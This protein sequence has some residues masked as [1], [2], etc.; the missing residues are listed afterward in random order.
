MLDA[1]TA[2]LTLPGLGWVMVAVVLAG[3]VYGFAGFGAALVYMPIA[4]IFL[5]PVIAVAAFALS[6]LI[7]LVTVVPRAWAN[8]DRRATVELVVAS[9]VGLPFGLWA[10]TTFD[11]TILR[12]AVLVVVAITL[13]VLLMGWRRK[14]KEGL[15][16]RAAIGAATGAVGGAT[17]LNGPVLVLFQL[18]SRD[19]AERSRANTICF[20]TFNS[21]LMLPVMALSGVLPPEAVP[22]GILM[23]IPYGLAGLAGQAMFNPAREGLYRTV[24]YAIIAAALVAGLPIWDQIL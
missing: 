7:S 10:L 14:T 5:E 15:T 11:A 23:L 2:A 9:L 1:F 12:W 4:T 17:G 22:L 21:I 24:A 6:A 3:L 13:A 8:A 18:S 20:L 16:S 19:G